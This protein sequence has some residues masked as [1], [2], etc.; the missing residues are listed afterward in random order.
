MERIRLYGLPLIAFLVAT[1]YWPWSM[2]GATTLRWAIMSLTIPAMCFLVAPWRSS[3]LPVWLLGLLLWS[4]PGPDITSATEGF[5]GWWQL[6]L[7]CGCVHLGS[8]M[9][10]SRA[11]KWFAYGLLPSVAIAGYQMAYGTPW[12]LVDAN[13]G[14]PGG[15]FINS[16]IMGETMALSVATI[17]PDATMWIIAAAL[18]VAIGVSGSRNAWLSL[19]TP[20]ALVELGNSWRYLWLTLPVFGLVLY[21]L[22]HGSLAYLGHPDAAYLITAGRSGMWLD[23]IHGLTWF[24][25]GIGQFYVDF[26]RYADAYNLNDGRPMYAHNEFLH[27]AFELGLPGLLLLVLAFVYALKDETTRAPVI[28]LLVECCFGFPL[29]TPASVLLAGLVL[30]R[31]LAPSGAMVCRAEY[32]SRVASIAAQHG[33]MGASQ[34]AHDDGQGSDSTGYVSAGQ[35]PVAHGRGISSDVPGGSDP[36][37]TTQ[38]GHSGPQEA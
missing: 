14:S 24:G 26:P 29:H 11:L 13:N 15:L 37:D 8:T 31:A 9:D 17:V 4:C 32:Y 2:T 21:G 27:F 6:A 20:L 16:R 30:G 19:S 10:T 25:H 22:L 5:N 1:A 34:C 7:L 3:W 36:R 35:H 28:V 38:P 12:W 18:L 23:T 33:S